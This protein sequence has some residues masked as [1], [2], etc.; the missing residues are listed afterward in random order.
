MAEHSFVNKILLVG[1]DWVKI[2]LVASDRKS[3]PYS[4]LAVL[5]VCSIPPAGP[6]L[7]AANV[8][9]QLSF[10]GGRTYGTIRT[11]NQYVVPDK[12]TGPLYVRADTQGPSGWSVRCDIGFTIHIP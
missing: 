2:D 1:G 7:S 6:L 4:T 8:D 11:G 9:L 5:N 12:I 10:N 3:Y